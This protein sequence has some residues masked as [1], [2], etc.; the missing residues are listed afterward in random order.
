MA[1]RKAAVD[2]KRSGRPVR[3]RPHKPVQPVKLLLAKMIGVFIGAI[4]GFIASYVLSQYFIVP[5]Q[6][7][8]QDALDIVSSA[9]T[10]LEEVDVALGR[11][12]QELAPLEQQ[13]LEYQRNNDR[14]DTPRPTPAPAPRRALDS[15]VEEEPQVTQ[16]PQQSAEADADQFDEEA[17]QAA[18]A[19][20]RKLYNKRQRLTNQIEL[21]QGEADAY[22]RNIDL[23]NVLGI[24]VV[25]VFSLLG[26]LLYPLTLR[27]LDRLSGQLESL[28]GNM[29]QRAIPATIGFFAGILIAI[30][31]ILAIF[32]TF[33]EGILSLQWFRLLFGAFIV[34]VLG[35]SGLL[36]GIAYFG[37][38]QQKQDPYA[39]Y[40]RPS[41]IKVLDTS[42]IIDGRVRD[43]AQAGFLDGS[44]VVTNSVLREL[45]NMADSSDDR[46]RAKG[47]RGLELL[48]T[49]QDDNR[50][51]VAVFD[52]SDF[53]A[54]AHSTDE[55]LIM[56]AQEMS[57][58]VVTN[59][60][61]LNRVAAIRDVRVINI[62]ALANAV[63]TN[64]LP[65][66]I[67]DISVV[68][69]GSQRGQGKG[70]L[71][72]GTMVV[73]EDGEPFIGKVKTIKLTSVT[74]T[75][76]GRMLFGRVDAVESGND[77]R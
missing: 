46:R 41:Q 4:F 64:H 73:I 34:V 54:Q 10:E 32:N 43:V 26:Y 59:D 44:L 36:V 11:A 14:E 22:R 47:R 74:Q 48:R 76:Q 1:G 2:K 28:T 70:Y 7:L 39:G 63:K 8:T 53:D 31:V 66:D 61:N 35:F 38:Q 40:R 33:S 17:Y 72:D 58:I 49:M 23:L 45:Q 20:Y 37:P 55:Q 13:W 24:V 9:S 56:L 42:V 77:N 27:L 18:S 68:D 51:D 6:G 71:E 60:Y 12:R 3:I 50:I 25:V 65:G 62:N 30:V 67:I 69:R 15:A 19:A 29:E 16:P 5:L 52:D 75:V 57:G 21:W